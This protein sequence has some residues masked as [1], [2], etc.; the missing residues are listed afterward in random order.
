MGLSEL[1]REY[2]VLVLAMGEHDPDFVDAYYGPA[3]LRSEARARGLT[4]AQ[5][6]EHAQTLRIQLAHAR[7]VDSDAARVRVRYLDRQL[8]SLITRS[9]VLTGKQLGFDAES[10]AI[11]DA[12]S[13]DLPDSYFE[14]R[15]AELERIVPGKG[16]LSERVERFRKRFEVPKEKLDAVLRAAIAGCKERTLAHLRLPADEAFTVE[17]VTDKPWGGYN[18]YQGH[19][20]SVI[21][22]NTSLPFQI[23]RALDLACHEGYPGH[24]V[25]NVLLEQELVVGRGYLEFTV[26]PLFS[27]QSLIAEGSA[28]Y[29]VELA[30]PGDARVAWEREHLFPLAGLSP[31]GAE[32]YYRA[33]RLTKELGYAVN[34]AACR[35]LDGEIDRGEAVR[36]IERYMLA[37]HERA[38]T[39]MRFIEKYRAYVINYNVGLDLVRKYVEAHAGSDEEARWRVFGELLASP[40]LPAQLQH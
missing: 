35:Y 21:Q 11:Y 24:H 37:N 23:E 8:A 36:F 16:A 32:A 27:S 1:A 4:L 7:D 30:F 26:Y 14:E 29:G 34:V 6:A 2:V 5:V 13:P 40:L 25:Y 17:Y 38:E 9:E 18:W 28:N 39:H 31:E 15:L 20:Q 22:V 10:R 19:Y 33:A 12:I 3:E